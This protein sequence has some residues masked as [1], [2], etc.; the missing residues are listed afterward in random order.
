MEKKAEAAP[1]FLFD[2]G[3]DDHHSHPK[4]GP[5]DS[6]TKNSLKLTE[7]EIASSANVFAIQSDIDLK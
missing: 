3:A 2:A 1:H 6:L 4:R 7:D 5:N